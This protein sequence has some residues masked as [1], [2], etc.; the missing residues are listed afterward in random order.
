MLYEVITIHQ[1]HVGQGLRMANLDVIDFGRRLSTDPL[2]DH[3][4][5]GCAV[6]L[7]GGYP[8]PCT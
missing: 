4:D 3:V 7:T 5:Q 8:L 2:T 1:G 6:R